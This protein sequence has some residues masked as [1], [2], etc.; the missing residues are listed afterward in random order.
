MRF[1][2]SFL[3]LDFI[4]AI[5]YRSFSSLSVPEVNNVRNSTEPVEMHAKR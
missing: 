5:D 4:I 3:S 2:G 1:Y